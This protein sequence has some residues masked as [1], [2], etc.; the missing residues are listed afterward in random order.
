MW[1]FSLFYLL[2]SLFFICFN[3]LSI[4][5]WHQMSIEIWWTTINGHIANIFLG[6]FSRFYQFDLFDVASDKL[7]MWTFSEDK[8]MQEN[9]HPL[10]K[11]GW[12]DVSRKLTRNKN[13]NLELAT[14]MR[15][16]TKYYA[17]LLIECSRVDKKNLFSWIQYY[18]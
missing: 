14:C 12:E 10:M 5:P 16:Y 11:N 6:F 2:L 18:K 7:Q 17:D 9:V 4:L 1:H 13:A 15:A 8:K 3:F